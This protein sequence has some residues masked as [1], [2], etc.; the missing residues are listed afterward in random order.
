MRI[1]VTDQCNLRCC[2]CM[3][4]EGIPCIDKTELLTFEE[5]ETIVRAGVSIGI[6]TIKITGGEPLLRNNITQLIRNIK[7]IK[8]IKQVTLTTNGVLLEQ[9]ADELKAAGIDSVNINL[10]AL[11]KEKYAAITRRDQ[12]IQIIEGVRKARDIEIPLKINCVSRKTM[13]DQELYGFAMIAKNHPIDIRF[14]EMMPLGYGKMY[15]TYSNEDVLQ[16]LKDLFQNKVHRSNIS[17]NGPAVYYEFDDLI[18]KIGFVSAVSHKFCS[19]CNR[20]RLSA[21]GN[22][23]LCLN[24]DSGVSL[25]DVLRN[26]NPALLKD[27]MEKAIY[28]KPQAHCFYENESEKVEMKNMVQI[29]G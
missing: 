26:D 25:K 15:D 13:T 1:S 16:R 27:V 6:N 7:N 12:F 5:I 20:I 22:L 10:P 28:E 19:D 9:Y 3:P 18:G 21:D 11:T 23:K 14:I 8:G 4:E 17:G 24:Y 29:G 2:Y